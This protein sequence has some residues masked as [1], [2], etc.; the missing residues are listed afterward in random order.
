MRED[1]KQAL[2]ELFEVS[3]ED[4]AF[5]YFQKGEKEAKLRFK[6]ENAAKDVATKIPRGFEIG[7]SMGTASVL[8]G[9]EEAHF[10][11]MYLR[12]LKKWKNQSRGHKRRGGFKEVVVERGR[13]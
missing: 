2:E 10:L 8:E 7:G 9:E 11:K 12:D 1:I 4:I 13:R 3:P 6:T 5:V